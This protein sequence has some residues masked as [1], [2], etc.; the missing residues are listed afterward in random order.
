MYSHAKRQSLKSKQHKVNNENELAEVRDSIMRGQ[1]GVGDQVINAVGGKG[2]A[3]VAGEK[4]AALLD[5]GGGFGTSMARYAD[6]T[7]ETA[8]KRKYF[9]VESERV[10][11]Q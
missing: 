8:Q 1:L 9:N 2:L 7:K 10:T 5:G 11:L 3:S 6:A 4:Q